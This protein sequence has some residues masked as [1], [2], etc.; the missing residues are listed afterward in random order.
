ME[1]KEEDDDGKNKRDPN[2]LKSFTSVYGY[3]PDRRGHTPLPGLV[4]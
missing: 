1:E 3:V 2:E 4:N